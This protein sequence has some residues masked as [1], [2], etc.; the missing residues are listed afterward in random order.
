MQRGRFAFAVLAAAIA[1]WS[2]KEEEEVTKC[3]PAVVID[4]GCGTVLGITDTSAASMVGAKPDNDTVYVN[5]FDLH[6][7]YQVPGK[8]LYITMRPLDPKEAPDCPGFIPIIY[9]HVKVLTVSESS[10]N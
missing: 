2:C 1:C 5:T 7:L 8:K 9:P 6:H 10:C 4:Q 3:Y